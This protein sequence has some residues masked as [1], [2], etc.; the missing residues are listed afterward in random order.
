[1]PVRD[2][3]LLILACLLPALG[4]CGARTDLSTPSSS[5]LDGGR[6]DGDSGRLD[7]RPVEA[8]CEALVAGPRAFCSIDACQKDAGP[9]AVEAVVRCVLAR[10]GAEPCGHVLFQLGASSGRTC[11][12]SAVVDGTNDRAAACVEDALRSSKWPC[13]VTEERVFVDGCSSL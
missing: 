4:G 8:A 5:E 10:C 6:A 11:G 1:M 9:G 13:A 3:R 7:A 2:S 12:M